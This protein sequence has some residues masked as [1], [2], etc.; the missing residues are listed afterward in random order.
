[1]S[2]SKVD[3]E[4]INTYLFMKYMKSNVIPKSFQVHSI[5]NQVARKT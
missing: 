2:I 3:C 1:M 4:I 5:I